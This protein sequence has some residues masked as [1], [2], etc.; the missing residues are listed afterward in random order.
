MSA[1][2]KSWTFALFTILVLSIILIVTMMFM[3]VARADFCLKRLDQNLEHKAGY[4]WQYR[5]VDGK[6]CWYYSNRLLPAEDLIWSFTE[7]EL[8]DD[9]DR[10][11]ER[12]F[13]LP[14]SRQGE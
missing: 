5:T 8:N 3:V 14:E 2:S 7:E 9:V 6:Q 11:V 12:K 1:T 10:V 4:R 13:Y